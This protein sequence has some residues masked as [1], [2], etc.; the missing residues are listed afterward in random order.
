MAKL[1][2][3]KTEENLRQALAEESQLNRYLLAYAR[4][5]ELEG[6]PQISRL[7]RALAESETV[8][9][10]SDLRTLGAIKETR[11]NL[12]EAT[13]RHTRLG[14]EMYPAMVRT[15]EEEGIRTARVTLDYARQ[16]ELIH[17]ELLKQAAEHLEDLPTGEY[18][19]CPVCG[20]TV[21]GRPPEACPICGTP[22]S[23]WMRVA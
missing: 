1:A 8:H 14:Q 12:Q 6:Y 4:Q 19:V 11:D 3:A 5:A 17:L 16:V 15:A 18:Y 2:G 23:A 20:N 21:F 13:L 9:A 10:N 22:G 7:L